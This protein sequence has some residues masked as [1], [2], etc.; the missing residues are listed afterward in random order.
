MREAI[1]AILAQLREEGI[2]Y[3]WAC[4][5]KENT[6]SETLIRSLGFEFQQEGTFDAE[7]DRTYELLEFRMT[8]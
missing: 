6:S 7:N 4:C 2:I 3:V 5:F 8:L 1:N